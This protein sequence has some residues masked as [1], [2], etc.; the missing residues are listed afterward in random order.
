MKVPILALI[1]ALTLTSAARAC[2]L[3]TTFCWGNWFD[4]QTFVHD[5]R[6]GIVQADGEFH[7]LGFGRRALRSEI[8]PD[9]DG[10]NVI[11]DGFVWASTSGG[12]SR[13]GDQLQRDRDARVRGNVTVECIADGANAYTVNVRL[14][15]LAKELADGSW[16]AIAGDSFQHLAVARYSHFAEF[17]PHVTVIGAFFGLRGEAVAGTFKY[18]R[19]GHVVEGAFG[20]MRKSEAGPLISMTR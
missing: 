20:A 12:V 10:V 15:G 18:D 17:L 6:Y 14:W 13:V 4:V 3:T 9:R 19:K 16:Q 11:Y 7:V 8:P 5:S 1:L 2:D